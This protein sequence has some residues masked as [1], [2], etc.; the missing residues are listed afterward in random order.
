MGPLPRVNKFS[1]DSLFWRYHNLPIFYLWY[2]I[3]TLGQED[4]IM[5]VG[6]R[7][8]GPG[9]WMMGDWWWPT[10]NAALVLCWSCTVRRIRK[11]YTL[12]R[13]PKMTPALNNEVSSD[14]WTALPLFTELFQECCSKDNHRGLSS[15]LILI[16][17]G[18][19]C[20]HSSSIEMDEEGSET[21]LD[22]CDVNLAKQWPIRCMHIGCSAES[23]MFFGKPGGC[24]HDIVN[25]LADIG[26][27]VS[28]AS[29]N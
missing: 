4:I 5:N 8:D 11:T 13:S 22:L 1:W 10:K 14:M 16:E 28:T 2:S 3:L 9:K 17:L 21:S 18:I 7:W 24:G 20:H 27:N 6:S 19:K 12:L 25:S 26:I 29:G 23:G 15:G